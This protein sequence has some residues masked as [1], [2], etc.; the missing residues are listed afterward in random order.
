MRYDA[1]S[2]SYNVLQKYATQACKNNGSFYTTDDASPG[3]LWGPAID[4]R[5]TGGVY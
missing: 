1:L 4:T 3:A 5:L 2:A